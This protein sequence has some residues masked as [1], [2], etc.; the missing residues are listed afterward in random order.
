MT[1]RCASLLF[2]VLTGAMTVGCGKP[3]KP[4]IPTKMIEPPGPDTES[5][6]GKK[7]RK[8]KHTDTGE[9]DSGSDK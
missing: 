2:A 8:P 6:K 1:R 9:G 3:D 7:E 4:S 5:G